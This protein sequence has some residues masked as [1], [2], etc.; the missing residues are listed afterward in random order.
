[1][2]VELPPRT[3]RIRPSKHILKPNLGTTSAHAENT[4]V[5]NRP[6]VGMWNYL[7]ARGE[8]HPTCC[9]EHSGLELPP[10]TRRIHRISQPVD[11]MPGTTSA[12]AENTTHQFYFSPN[13]GN[14]LRA[15]GEYALMLV[16]RRFG[17]ELPPRTRR[18]PGVSGVSGVSGGTT[19]AHAENTF[20]QHTATVLA[21]NYLRARGEYLKAA[22]DAQQFE[23]LPPRTRR[24]Q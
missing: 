5:C 18:I 7:R 8:Y 17:V 19:S 13:L 21:W 24:I 6:S 22:L 23:E 3:R 15:R 1:M 16:T 20:R 12:H 14:Y 9:G 10:R 4:V 11:D 2:A